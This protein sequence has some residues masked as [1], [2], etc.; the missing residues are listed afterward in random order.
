MLT[1]NMIASIILLLQAFGVSQPTIDIVSA[2][3][4]PQVVA[5][6]SNFIPLGSP[7][8]TGSVV[9]P[10]PVVYKMA[11]EDGMSPPDIYIRSD[12]E[13]D[14]TELTIGDSSISFTRNFSKVFTQKDC[15]WTALDAGKDVPDGIKECGGYAERFVPSTQL[16]SGDYSIYVNASL[17]GNLTVQ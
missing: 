10:A 17:V 16:S 12:I 9:S 15:I 14:P 3:L 7:N 1:A 8:G 4:T 11:Y 5:G 2:E 13:I 6:G